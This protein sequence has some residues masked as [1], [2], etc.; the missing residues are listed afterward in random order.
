MIPWEAIA[1]ACSDLL[2]KEVQNEGE[3]KHY[4][5]ENS[6]SVGKKYPFSGNDSDGPFN[7]MLQRPDYH[8]PSMSLI[9]KAMTSVCLITIDDGVWASG[10]VLN[11]QGLILTN[12]HLLE[13]WRFGKTVARGGSYGAEPEVPFIP[14]KESVYCRNEAPY[15]HQKCQDLLPEMLKFAGSSVTDGDGGYKFRSTYIGHRNIRVRLDYTDP[16]IW[17]DARV[18][19]VSTGPLDIAL[20]QLEFV[21]GQLSPIIMDFACP[22]AGSKAYVI[23]HGLFGPRCG[24]VL[25]T[26]FICFGWIWKSQETIY[27]IFWIS[28]IFQMH[29]IDS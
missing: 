10:V 19:Y 15:S 13:P 18:V 21:P 5:R 14:S 2:Q 9:E 22:L 1:T 12:A 23:G 8:N 6:N 16:R 25:L 7:L 11:N 20:L 26:L 4:N 3:K 27:I 29:R 17:C 28:L 24:K